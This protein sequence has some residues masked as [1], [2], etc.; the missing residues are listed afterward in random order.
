MAKPG[1]TLEPVD[2]DP[3][4]KKETGYTLQPIDYDPFA[5]KKEATILPD[6]DTSSDFMRGI[7]NYLPQLQE[8]YGGAKALVGATAKKLGAEQFGSEMIRS[9]AQS[10]EAGQ[11]GQ[12]GRESDSLTKAWE[13]GLGSVITDWLP[14]QVGSGAANIAETLGVTAVGAITGFVLGKGVG[15]VPGGIAGFV[16]KSLVKQGVKEA[17]EKIVKEQGEEAGRKFIEAE[18]KK[19]LRSAGVTAGLATQAAGHGAGE[20]TSRAMQEAAQRGENPE[21]IDLT[22]VLPAAV[23][24]GVADFV[25]NKI[26]LDALK[27]GDQAGKYL[28]ADILKRVA[29]TGAKQVPAEE[30]QSIAERY[31][32]ELSLADAEALRE[33]IDTAGAAFGMSVVPGSVGAVRT[34]LA[35]KVAADAK[36]GEAQQDEK[37][38][39]TTTTAAAKELNPPVDEETNKLLRPATDETGTS[40]VSVAP[41]TVQAAAD[42]TTPTADGVDRVEK[43]VTGATV[44]EQAAASEKKTAPAAPETAAPEAETAAETYIASL[45]SDSNKKP[46]ASVLKGLTKKLGITVEPGEGFNTRAVQAIK[47]HLAK[48]GAP[49]VATTGPVAPAGGTSTS[50]AGQ[51]ATVTAPARTTATP[52]GGVVPTGTTPAA[53]QAGAGAQPASV[54]SER[55]ANVKKLTERRTELMDLVDDGLPPTHPKFK[56]KLKA[57]NNLEQQ[58]GLALS[59]ATNISSDTEPPGGAVLPAKRKRVN[60]KKLVEQSKKTG[61]PLPQLYAEAYDTHPSYTIDPNLSPEANAE[62]AAKLMAEQEKADEAEREQLLKASK[63]E[64]EVRYSKDNLPEN[65]EELYNDTREENPDLP[66]WYKLDA[67]EKD[68]YFSRI[69]QNSLAEHAN[70]A[71]ALIA[72]RK[73]K[74]SRAGGY[75][76][77]KLTP[78]QRRTINNYEE[79]RG[80]AS[81]MFGVQFPRWGDLSAAARNIYLEQIVNNAGLQMDVAFAKTGEQI[82]RERTDLTEQ[83][84][85]Q[86]L[87]N[88]QER[89][90]EVREQAE[91]SAEATR[92]RNE[93]YERSAGTEAFLPGKSKERLPKKVVEHLRAGRLNAALQELADHLKN[94]PD[95]RAKFAGLI[96]QRLADLGLKTRVVISTKPLS[97]GDLAQY[98]P[99]RDVVVIGPNG[100]STSTL[101]HEVTHAG[102]VRTM[103]LYLSGKKNML[104]EQQR[105]GVEQILKIMFA[106]KA[107]L[108]EDHPNAYDNPYEFIAYAMNDDSFKASLERYGFSLTE[109]L[110]LRQMALDSG[111]TNIANA[112]S[113]ELGVPDYEP[114]VPT[115]KSMWSAFKRAVAG[116]IN[117]AK[118]PFKNANFVMELSAA[119]DDILS[120]PTEPININ[121]TLS[122]KEN[123][124]VPPERDTDLYTTGDGYAPSASEAPRDWRFFRK[125]LLTVPGWQRIAQV[126]QNDRQ[127]IK[128]WENVH[129]LAGLI[130]REGKDKINNIYEQIVRASGMARNYY[131]NYVSDAAESLDKAVGAFTKA[132]GLSTDE[133]LAMLHKISEA[134]HEPERRL[135]KYLL[136]VPLKTD[137]ILNGGTLSPADRRAQIIQLLDS[138]KLTESQAKQL[139]AELEAIVKKYADALGSSPREF[140]PVSQDPATRQAQLAERIN[141]ES[142]EYNVTG[143]TRAS[144]LKI[145]DQ[146]ENHPNKEQ[147]EAV[148]DAVRRL[149]KATT[150][151]NKIANYWSQPVSNRVAFYDFA[152]YVPL[153]GPPKHSEIDEDLDL[154]TLTTGKNGKEHQEYEQAFGGRFSIAN[155]PIL[156]T[157]SDATRAA[158]RAGRKDLTQS[159][160]NAITNKINGNTLLAGEI[161]HHIEFKDRNNV[162]LG[163]LKGENT[164]FHYN[165]DG[166]IDVLVIRDKTLRE[167]VRRTYK[168]THPVVDITNKLTST[169]GK[170]HTRYNYQFAPMNFVRDALTNAFTIGAEMGPVKAAQFIMDISTM[171]VAKNGLY[172]AMRVAALYEKGDAESQKRMEELAKKDPYMK[173]MID[174]I[175]EGGMVSYLQ[176]ISIK[177]N[178]QQLQKEVGRS[179]ILRTKE[180]MEKFIDVWTDMFELASRSAAYRIA[181]QNAIQRGESKEAATARAVAYAKN[182]ANF[183]QVGEL[184]KTMGAFYM[185]FRP[186]A[187]GAVRAIE[188]VAPAFNTLQMAVDRLPPS[189]RNN[190]EAL[191]KFKQEYSFKQ[192][193]AR[194]MITSLM[195]L[196]MMAYFMAQMTSDD[197]DLG[198]NAVATDNMQQWTRF[199]RFH[200]PKSVSKTLGLGE[201]IV[202]QIPWGFGLGAFAAA[203]A[204]LAAVG[205]GSQSIKDALQNI[206][207]Q[208]SLDSFVPIPVSRIPPSEEPGAFFLDSI[209]PSIARPILEF[210]LNKNGLGQEI[211]NDQSRRMGDAYTGGDRIPEIYKDAARGLANSTLGDIDISPN[212]LYFLSNS[213]IDG[214][215]RVF[216]G[217]YGINDLANGRKQFNAKT[218]IPLMGSFFGAKS[219]VDS[220]EFSA[221]ERKVAD[222][223]R[224]IKMF[225]TNPE[226]AGLYDAEHPFDR[227]IVDYYNDRVNADLKDLRSQAKEIRLMSGL[228]PKDRDALLKVV[229]FQQNLVKYQMLQNFKAYGIEP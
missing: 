16:G 96:A 79:N 164:I 74:G 49:S 222:I 81:R 55:E 46:N 121:K 107:A 126:F 184:G 10:M 157:M 141:P 175:R 194:I 195:G 2:F 190:P 127:P 136:T 206:F 1:Y 26:G 53:T 186:A 29:V 226:M 15:A 6:T 159:I 225:D 64:G 143:L 144:V 213:Y 62:A 151:L 114:M 68:V 140:A 71:K 172:K 104:S 180:Q 119:F 209:T 131:N 188:A 99:E 23:V 33:Y 101:L 52:A 12:V 202:F 120:P 13:K 199:A 124:K 146:Y 97:D 43:D 145:L 93:A 90:Q 95:K 217:L 92:K 227:L 45:G 32:A 100:F 98:D 135:V 215:G 105:K 116:V 189:I 183:E 134:L 86:E 72:Y 24:H 50:V 4:A 150:D 192:S 129:D 165:E 18:T 155:N 152:N 214:L 181:R 205:N 5:K 211:Y 219:N 102:T 179:G 109:A 35:G 171:V 193:S 19:V 132:A 63:Q 133:A 84:K 154:E 153:K 156:Q 38:S 57:L 76:Q 51:P 41:A 14:Y 11:A 89:Q 158:M 82:M 187:T 122:A 174:F 128:A 3:F 65:A 221:V 108:S 167:A 198:R 54:T 218:D 60:V 148:M 47:D 22:R 123:K 173:D 106:T 94:N 7:R 37:P 228:D 110:S 40:L 182:L 112:I 61:E 42:T 118:S 28:I 170:F 223:E 34:R 191:E 88:L 80:I 139:R 203:G 67:D 58:L 21:N 212:T 17:A 207:L 130:F 113:E 56:N 115:D 210:V 78:E 229:V 224:K 44:A 168:D 161:A 48:K 200:I 169:L 138:K 75:G 117:F 176:G 185:F 166:S 39:T 196:G 160:K 77:E 30:I 87:K 111:Q 69:R 208:I 201:D 162:D 103:Y 216:E 73:E 163:E 137:N 59:T 149:H 178:F 36:A 83:Q 31:G 66:Q 125:M 85:A 8:T 142:A 20:V 197:D 204:Q 9:G 70:A 177:S 91:T 147:I 220:R 25:I 27:I